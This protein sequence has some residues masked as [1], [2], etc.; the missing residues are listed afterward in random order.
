MSKTGLEFRDVIL[1]SL[2]EKGYKLIEITVVIWPK[3]ESDFGKRRI[4]YERPNGTTGN[5][6]LYIDDH[7]TRESVKA[8]ADEAL[9]GES[10][11]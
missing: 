9:S 11:S 7:S 4:Y 5:L 6:V 8:S 1:Q 3:D 10:L 2:R